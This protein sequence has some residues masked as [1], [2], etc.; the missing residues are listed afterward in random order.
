[1]FKKIF[2]LLVSFQDIRGALYNNYIFKGGSGKLRLKAILLK[3]ITPPRGNRVPYKC[4]HVHFGAKAGRGHEEL[5]SIPAPPVCQALCPALQMHDLTCVRCAE[6]TTCA[7]D[8]WALECTFGAVCFTFGE[9]RLSR[10]E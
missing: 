1:M 10:N 9:Q 6:N 4:T 2:Y 3:S 7:L 5:A 8:L